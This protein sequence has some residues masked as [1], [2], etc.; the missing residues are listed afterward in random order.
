MSENLGLRLKI[1]VYDWVSV[2]GCGVT[3]VL[4]EWS[5]TNR[6]IKHFVTKEPEIAVATEM[7]SNRRS[8]NRYLNFLLDLQKLVDFL[9]VI[10][11]ILLAAAAFDDNNCRARHAFSLLHLP[12]IPDLPIAFLKEIAIKLTFQV[13]FSNTHL[14]GVRL[15]CHSLSFWSLLNRIWHIHHAFLGRR[16]LVSPRR[17]FHCASNF[18]H[19]QTT[20]L[21][22]KF[23]QNT[24]WLTVKWKL[25]HWSHA[26]YDLLLKKKQVKSMR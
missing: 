20:E 26:D 8:C 15:S 7:L 10:S 6:S 22:N 14:C 5:E 4:Y 9:I 13:N 18:F 25:I 24:V 17:D 19:C 21:Q 16:T 23:P 2:S 11:Q 1:W 3:N 12:G